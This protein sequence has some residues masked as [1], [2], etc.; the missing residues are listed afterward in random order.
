MTLK[1]EL[2]RESKFKMTYY[3]NWKKYEKLYM[4]LKKEFD[5][6]KNHINHNTIKKTNEQEAR[7][8]QIL[9][10]YYRMAEENKKYWK[11]LVKNKLL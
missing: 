3:N 4:D 9:V 10:E 11:I 2:E 6:Y 5:E 7:I 1:E 8:N